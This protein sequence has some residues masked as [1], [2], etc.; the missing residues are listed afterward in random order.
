ML[1]AGLL[2]PYPSRVNT[3]FVS[4]GTARSTQSFRLP[5]LR[6]LCTNVTGKADTAVDQ[7]LFGVRVLSVSSP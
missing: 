7:T 5:I 2:Y 4:V 6:P 3:A 1:R